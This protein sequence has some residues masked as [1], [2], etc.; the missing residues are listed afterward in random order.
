MATP[1]KTRQELDSVLKGLLAH[2]R[3][4][5]EERLARPK[6]KGKAAIKALLTAI[7]TGLI[8]ILQGVF[9]FSIVMIVVG[10]FGLSIIVCLQILTDEIKGDK[11]FALATLI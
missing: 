3:R 9:M 2:A 7:T 1:I 5:E 6:L 8:E 10:A 4:L 11:L